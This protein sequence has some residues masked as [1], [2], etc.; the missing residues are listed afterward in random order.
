MVEG[1]SSLLKRAI[2]RKLDFVGTVVASTEMVVK[3]MFM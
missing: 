3:G 1:E 2:S